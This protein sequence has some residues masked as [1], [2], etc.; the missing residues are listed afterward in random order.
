MTTQDNHKKLQWLGFFVTTFNYIEVQSK[1]IATM[2]G[3]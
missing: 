2:K 1:L 3:V